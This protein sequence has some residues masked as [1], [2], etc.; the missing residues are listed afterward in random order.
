MRLH[1][2]SCWTAVTMQ[3]GY[4]TVPVPAPHPTLAW[5]LLCHESD[6]ICYDASY[7]VFAR[8]PQAQ[9]P[10]PRSNQATSLIHIHIHS[11]L[12]FTILSLLSFPPLLLAFSS[13][14][15]GAIGPPHLRSE[16]K[17]PSLISLPYHTF[18]QPATPVLTY[19]RAIHRSIDKL[20]CGEILHTLA[21]AITSQLPDRITILPSQV[22]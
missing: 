3:Y 4:N 22:G 8:I 2:F 7:R 13:C 15:P 10:I 6:M 9:R 16:K 20:P 21:S 17:I 1:S 12:S 18:K 14:L 11:I 19:P 5:W